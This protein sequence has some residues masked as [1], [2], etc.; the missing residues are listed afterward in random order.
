MES[1]PV[2][3]FVIILVLV[4]INAFFAA[5]EMAIVSLNKTKI[6][7]LAESGNKKALSIQKLLKEPSN[8]LSTIQVGITLAGFFASASA[9]TGI[10]DNFA[11]V[12]NN[13][14]I[15]YSSQIAFFAVTIF[16]SYLTLV[17]G[18]LLPKR[19]ALQKSEGV[20]MFA[21]NPLL[22]LSKIAKPFVKFLSFSTNMLIKLLGM[23]PNG[24]EEQ[25]SE[26]E[27][28]SIV[29]VGQEH[30]IINQTEKE[31]IDSIIGFDD[32]I[33]KE[34]MT[35]RCEVF[36]ID[37]DS[38]IKEIVSKIT[39]ENFSRIPV[40]EGDVDSIVGIVY[41]KDLFADTVKHGIENVSIKDIMREPY[42]VPQTKNIDVLFKDLQKT[43]HHM[44]ILIDEYGGFA[45]VA[46]IEDLLEEVVGNIFDEHDEKEYEIQQLE[47][48]CYIVDGLVTLEELNDI[49]DLDL[50]SSDS[51]TI[52]GFVME[53]L[54]TVPNAL[55]HNE[56]NYKNTI[57][58]VEE[59]DEK[60]IDKVKVII[61]K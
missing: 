6:N 9:A 56:I 30:G 17:F 37:I 22:F 7:I 34:V 18:E 60:R 32:K 16:I 46:T 12:L 51:D 41:L 5:S 43:Q 2:T 39:E 14:N 53:L 24:L 47:D 1:D 45:G 54:D 3:S 26:E 49:L 52:G 28:R 55:E 29:E 58:L 57:F 31:M 13:F 36:M 10:S 8:F 35:P 27:L 38:D 11:V 50:E 15:P 48:N 59:M 19:I 44:A 61:N 20:A 23:N 4:L 42:F 25:I 21:I 40:F 33:A